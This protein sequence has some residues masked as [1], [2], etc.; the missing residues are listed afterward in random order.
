MLAIIL[1]NIL[2]S[3]IDS[4]FS[5]LEFANTDNVIDRIMNSVYLH[6]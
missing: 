2:L 1:I 3:K 6:L 5:S 4:S